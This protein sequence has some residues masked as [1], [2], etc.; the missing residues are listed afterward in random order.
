LIYRYSSRELDLM[1]KQISEACRQSK[2]LV[3][4]EKTPL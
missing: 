1:E 3:K 2:P 4:L